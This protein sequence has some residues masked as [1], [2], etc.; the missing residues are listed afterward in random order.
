MSRVGKLYRS[1][2]WRIAYYA[3]CVL[4]G[5]LGSFARLQSSS[6]KS[7]VIVLDPALIDSSGHHAEFAQMLTA[8]LAPRY[9]VAVY[10]NFRLRTRLA[11]RVRA[12]PIFHESFYV[13]DWTQEF[14]WGKELAKVNFDDLFPSTIVVV[15]TAT[16][17][18]LSGLSK[19]FAALPAEHRPKLFL[20]FQHPLEHGI[21]DET[22]WPRA[23]SLARQAVGLMAAIG[24]V[25]LASNCRSLAEHVSQRLD[26]RCA[27]MPLPIRWPNMRQAT[28]APLAEFGF[29]GGLRREKGAA[30]IAA[31]VPRF[32]AAHP[33][34]R[35]I[36]H[37]AAGGT[38]REDA[39][40]ILETHPQVE[41]I[42]AVFPKKTDYFEHFLKVDCCLL[43][44][45]P[46]AYAVRTSGILFEAL[47][48]GRM[49]ITTRGSWMEAELNSRGRRAFLM[50][51]FHSDDLVQCL[52][53][54]RAELLGRSEVRSFDASIISECNAASFCGALDELMRS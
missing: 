9:D 21:K 50:E 38:E 22:N 48:L 25:R 30:I 49:I 42:H 47:G 14:P 13:M 29:F 33:D 6:T 54:A 46:A 23:I 17:P 15:H 32:L 31:A 5:A 45:D 24:T 37:A 18:Q 44:Y 40:R 39:V 34:A 20:Q 35:F 28:P 4:A 2:I 41:L 1:L 52:E 26:Q 19:W 11:I 51:R 36:I 8:E 10:S 12:Q 7:K 16:L 27:V 3:R 53:Q 43:P